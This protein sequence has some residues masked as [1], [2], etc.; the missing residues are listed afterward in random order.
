MIAYR[1]YAGLIPRHFPI[2]LLPVIPIRPVVFS[3]INF[4]I[5]LYHLFLYW[6]INRLYTT[7]KRR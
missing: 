3:L 4:S 5:F 6:Y 1:I 7:K 2:A